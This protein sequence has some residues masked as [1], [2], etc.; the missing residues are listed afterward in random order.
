MDN[1]VKFIACISNTRE[2]IDEKI[3]I[4]SLIKLDY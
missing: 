4:D 3:K 2:L 1:G